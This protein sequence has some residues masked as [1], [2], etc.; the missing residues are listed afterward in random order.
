[1]TNLTEML[2]ADIAAFLVHANDATIAEHNRAAF[3]NGAA[4]SIRQLAGEIIDNDDAYDVLAMYQ[5]DI[6]REIALSLSGDDARII[7]LWNAAK[8]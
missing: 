5:C 1:M 4:K 2:K 3:A 8:L 7:E 6:V